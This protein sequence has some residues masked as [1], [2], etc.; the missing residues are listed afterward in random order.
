MIRGLWWL[1]KG[2]FLDTSISDA[3][4]FSVLMVVTPQ[5]NRPWKGRG[6]ECEKNTSLLYC[7]RRVVVK[8]QKRKEKW[9]KVSTLCPRLSSNQCYDSVPIKVEDL[10]TD[11][12]KNHLFTMRVLIH[13]FKDSI[14]YSTF[15]VHLRYCLHVLDSCIQEQ[16]A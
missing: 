14:N 4:F 12:I 7:G 15:Q 16:F 2:G 5:G 1:I 8:G 3:S 10:E 11:S 13:Q 6:T 9:Q